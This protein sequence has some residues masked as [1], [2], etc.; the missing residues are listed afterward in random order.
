MCV[1]VFGGHVRREG[2]RLINEDERSRDVG[3]VK[4]TK[5]KGRSRPAR[6]DGAEGGLS[7]AYWPEGRSVQTHKAE[8]AMG[9]DHRSAR[10]PRREDTHPERRH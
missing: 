1:C 6:R 5:A 4:A 10:G 7:V 3:E 2:M 9:C 8:A